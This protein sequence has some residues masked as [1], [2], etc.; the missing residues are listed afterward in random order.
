MSNYHLLGLKILVSNV[1]PNIKITT[2]SWSRPDPSVFDRIQEKLKLN[3]V[4]MCNSEAKLLITF[5]TLASVSEYIEIMML[6][7]LYFYARRITKIYDAFQWLINITIGFGFLCIIIEHQ[8]FS[9]KSFIYPI[10]QRSTNYNSSNYM[11]EQV[12]KTFYKYKL[13]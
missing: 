4:K 6:Y 7:K 3:G 11:P 10:F 1:P 13:M 12:I 5:S 8:N 2:F 9:K